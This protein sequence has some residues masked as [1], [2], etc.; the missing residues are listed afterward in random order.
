MFLANH[1]VFSGVH[2]GLDHKG[3]MV[4]GAPQTLIY[5]RTQRCYQ[6]SSDLYPLQQV[7]GCL[8][9]GNV[10]GNQ[11]P[12][13][14]TSTGSFWWW[15]AVTLFWAPKTPST[16]GF[17]IGHF[18]WMERNTIKISS[19]LLYARTAPEIDNNSYEIT[20]FFS[21]L[22]KRFILIWF[23][24]MVDSLKAEMAAFWHESLLQS[25]CR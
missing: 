5:W 21:K 13:R 7:L 10:R 24:T 15:E 14:R 1:P 8:P 6:A 22:E 2:P 19:L 16:T 12:L 9:E 25:W 3:N 20:S 18:Q 11:I 17:S 23:I 4:S